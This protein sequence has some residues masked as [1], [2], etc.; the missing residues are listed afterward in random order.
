MI[1]G[2][3]AAVVEGVGEWEAGGRA[4][5]ERLRSMAAIWLSM[6]ST[7]EPWSEAV[8]ACEIV[9]LRLSCWSVSCR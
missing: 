6:M 5:R 1:T 8:E 3:V 4:G 7:S 2:S 9:V